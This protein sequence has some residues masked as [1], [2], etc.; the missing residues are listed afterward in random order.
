MAART[1]LD[2]PAKRS[3]V[4]TARLL[5]G[6]LTSSRS[7]ALAIPTFGTAQRTPVRLETRCG[8]LTCAPGVPRGQGSSSSDASFADR[9]SRSNMPIPQSSPGKWTMPF[10]GLASSKD[11][12]DLCNVNATFL[13][14]A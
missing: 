11:H 2:D 12:F 9:P 3:T 13:A 7:T 4:S 5:G 14:L 10:W 1:M 6:S 8:V